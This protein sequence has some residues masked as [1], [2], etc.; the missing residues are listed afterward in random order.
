MWP[1]ACVDDDDAERG[2]AEGGESL[3]GREQRHRGTLDTVAVQDSH[4]DHLD[5]LVR[6]VRLVR[7]GE[8]I[9]LQLGLL[10]SWMQDPS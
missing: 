4:L 3:L 9:L 10:P 2:R 7:P 5:H 8:D 6:L 1:R